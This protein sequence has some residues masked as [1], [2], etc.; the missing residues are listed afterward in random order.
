ML[1][2]HL[3]GLGFRNPRSPEGA[4]DDA[5]GGGKARS[6]QARREMKLFHFPEGGPAWCSWHPDGCDDLT[7]HS[8][9]PIAPATGHAPATAEIKTPGRSIRKL[10]EASGHWDKVP[11]RTLYITLNRRRSM[12]IEKRVPCASADVNA[13]VTL[14]VFST[15]HKELPAE[16]CP[17]PRRIRL[18]P[19]VRARSGAL[20]WPDAVA[21]SPRTECAHLL[22]RGPD[23]GPNAQTSS[24]ACRASYRDAWSF[25]KIR[26]QTLDPARGWRRLRPRSG[27]GRRPPLEKKAILSVRTNYEIDPGEGRVLRPASSTSSSPTTIGGE[28]Q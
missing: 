18:L 11:L 27:T 2:A 28:M 14:Q 6:P 5:R 20:P 21:A 26:H 16:S 24:T 10:W 25:T 15:R 3:R 23:R 4:P 9:L 8:G 22:H 17:A 12:R 1:P 13:P 7:A 19:P